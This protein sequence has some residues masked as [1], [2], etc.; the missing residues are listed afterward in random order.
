MLV[1]WL[2]NLTSDDCLVGK[3]V[4]CGWSGGFRSAL[5]AF[6]GEMEEDWWL[7]ALGA[8]AS[9]GSGNGGAGSEV[10]FKC[11]KYSQ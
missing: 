6:E 11:S 1:P 4:R 9:K 5:Q 8:V 3:S 10:G 7:H 2:C